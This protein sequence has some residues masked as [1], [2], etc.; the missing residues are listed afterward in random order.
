MATSDVE[1]G[2]G[3]SILRSVKFLLNCKEKG[4]N[5][6]NRRPPSIFI[7]PRVYRDLS[8]TSFNPTLVSIGPLH[9]KDKDLQKFEV[10][11]M[12]YLHHLLDRSGSNPEQTL[13][14]CVRKVSLKIE[15]IKSCYE[16]TTYNDEELATMMVI[17]ACFILYFIHLISVEAG[18][19]QENWSIIPL[20]VHDMVLIENQIPF[21]VLKD[22]FESTFPHFKPNTSLTDHLKILLER[23]SFFMEYEVTNNINLDR[24]HDHILGILHYCLQP[25]HHPLP[26]S[27]VPMEQKRHSAMEL[28]RAGVKFMPNE[29]AN[30][31]MAMKLELPRNLILYEQCTLVPEY[32]TSYCWAID[33][34]VDTPEDVVKL[35]KS[36]VLVN[37][38]GS[39]ESAVYILNNICNDITSNVFYY[40]HQW[41]RLD[42]YYKSYW[43]NAAAGLK[44]TYFSSPWNIISVFAAIILFVL[45]LIQTIFTIKC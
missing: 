36:G 22:I 19:F 2:G 20:I 17:D 35:I 42:T 44:R 34:L 7:V 43:P 6:G 26:Y 30:W 40:Y 37:D 45:T 33:M 10:Q 15:E 41:E 1:V 38:Y 8:P 4:R 28:D 12:T 3:D 25:V 29:D 27:Q 11:K 9:R 23:Y 32:V 39:N 24:T 5:H 13:Q 18:G 16:E 21:F 14:E 31:A